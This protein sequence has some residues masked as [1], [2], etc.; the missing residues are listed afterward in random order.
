MIL[1]VVTQEIETESFL[2][3]EL[4]EIA[5]HFTRVIVITT[6]KSNKI[7]NKY[8][9]IISKKTDFLFSS[10]VH[11]IKKLFSKEVYKELRDRKS[12]RVK[13]GL[14]SLIYNWIMTW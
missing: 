14:K 11:S 12:M 2:I 4:N 1:V 8:E 13:P 10:I 6:Q 7:T 5:H 3:N 9:T